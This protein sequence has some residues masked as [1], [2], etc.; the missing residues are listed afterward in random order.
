MKSLRTGIL[1]GAA[2][3]LLAVAAQAA[4][5]AAT[6]HVDKASGVVVKVDTAA[7]RLDVKIGT[8]S[9]EFTLVPATR[10]TQGTATLGASQLRAGDHV[11]LE[12]KTVAGAR[13]LSWVQVA[14]THPATGTPVK[15]SPVRR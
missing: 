11:R 13:Q 2:A 9:E 12:W 10:I 7:N 8:A 15:A 5:N 6:T 3:L 1:A 4:T 14:A